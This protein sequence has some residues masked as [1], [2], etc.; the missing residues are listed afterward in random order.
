M[1]SLVKSSRLPLAT[2]IAALISLSAAPQKANAASGD[3]TATA[4]TPASWATATNWSS[5]PTVPGSA[6][7]DVI[8][9]NSNIAAAYTI[10]LDGTRTMG[11][12]LV[13]DSDTTAAFTLA[14]GTSGVLALDGTGTT[15]ALVRFGVAGSTLGI[16]NTISAPITLVDNARFYT[17]LTAA[18]Q[19]VSGAVSGT[20]KS[21]TFDNDDGTTLAGPV[22][23]Q[24]QYF[25]TGN[26]TYTGGTTIDD[27][28]VRIQTNNTALGAAGSAVVIQ[29]GGQVFNSTGLTNINYTFTIAGNGW[30]E[31]AGQLGA[32]RLD[33]G[34][35][36]TGTVAMSANAAIGSN[37]GTGTVSG[38]ISGGFA[39][40]KVGV[41]TITLGGVN[42]YTG[43]TTIA[44]GTVNVSTIGNTGVTGNLGTNST[45]NLGSGS[46]NGI[47]NYTGAGETNNRVLN[48][49]G[50]SGG[51]NVNAN[52][53]GLLR[54]TSN[55]TT[56]G[57]G[58]KGLNF[59]GSGNGQL[60]GTI[61][62]NTG[63][64]NFTKSGT[65]TWNLAGDLTLG[66]GSITMSGGAL[67]LGGNVSLGGGSI[68]VTAGTLNLSGNASLG[69]GNVTVGAGTTVTMAGVNSSTG[70]YTV[71]AGGR[72][73]LTSGN[74]NTSAI[75]VNGIIGGEGSTTG[76][77]TMNSASSVF[78]TVAAPNA[79]IKSNGVTFNATTGLL[80]DA[81]PV[82]G[83]YTVV[84]YG[85]A[86]DPS[87]VN[88]IGARGGF[89][90]DTTDGGNKKVIAAVSVADRTW[91]TT[92]GIWDTGVTTSW[93]EGDQKFF[94][95]DS[96][97]F[98]EPAAPSTVTLTG[99]LFPAAITVNNTTNSYT[100]AGT[101]TIG[102]SASLTKTGAGTLTLNSGNTFTGKTTV[103][104]GVLSVASD[105]S[106]GA[107]PVASV[108]DQLSLN[109]TTLT[110][111]AAGQTL[112]ATRGI[113]IGASSAIFDTS[114]LAVASVTTVS[115]N[116]IGSNG[117]TIAAN[118]DLSAS[119]AGNGGLFRLG[120]NNSGLTGG[121]AITAGLVAGANNNSFGVNTI[122]LSN[123][124]G[125][126]DP[127]VNLTLTNDIVVAAS[128]GTIRVYG[129]ATTNLNGNIS[130]TGTLQHT[131]GGTLR[132][133]GAGAGYLGTFENRRGTLT[134]TGN[135]AN[136]AGTDINL[137]TAGGALTF[138]G[139]GTATVNSVTSTRDVFIQNGM[140]LDVDSGVI[141][142]NTNGHWWQTNAGT[143]GNLTSSGGTLTVTNGAATGSL[144]VLDHQIRVKLVDFNGV[145]P[146]AFVKNNNN[147]L[148]V[149]QANTFTGGTTIN[150][151]R[152]N[153]D[154]LA[155]FGA[156]TVTVNNGGQTYLTQ[157]GAYANNFVLNGN[158]VVEAAGTLG[159]LRMGGNSVGSVTVASPAR[160]VSTSTGT[161]NGTL[162]GSAALE[163]N[164]TDAASTGTVSLSG[165]GAGYTGTAT[166]T[167]GRFNFASS[168]GGS[169]VVADGASLGAGTT[170]GADLTLGATTGTSY[171]A[172]AS[173]LAITGN[174]TLNGVS[175][176]TFPPPYPAPGTTTVPLMTYGGT[177][178]GTGAN[179]AL[180]NVASYR[181]TPAFDTT[182][183]GQVNLTG[184]DIKNLTWSG[185]T[186]AWNIKT[187]TNWNANV[188]VFATADRV[189]F[190]DTGVTTAVTLNG[191]L[192]PGSVTVSSTAN[193]YVLTASAGNVIGG[194]SS[195]FK[196]GTSTLTMAGNVAH[197]F[198]GGTTISQGAINVQNAGSLGTGTVTLGDASTGANNIALY[199]DTNRTTFAIP[200]VI[201]NNGSGT[202]TIGSRATV[203]GAGDN[204]QFTNIT[205]QRDAIFDSN[206]AD[207][208]DYENVSGTGNITVTGVGRSVFITPNTF[209]GNLNIATTGAGYF[210]IGTA[211][212]GAF[213]YIPDAT[214][215]TVQS[216][217]RF[218]VSVGAETIDALNG[219]GLVNVNAINA[220]LTVG[221]AGGSGD[222]GGVLANATSI[223]SLTKAG[224][225]TQI[226]SGA[227]TYTGATTINGGTLQVGNG[228]A[229][230]QLGTGAVT[231]AAGTKLT[232]NRSGAVGQGALNSTAVGNGT[233]NINGGAELSL[234]AGGNFSGIVN[235]NNGTLVFNT[236]N[237]TG[238]AASSATFNLSPGTTL[239]NT[240]NSTHGHIGNITL[241]AATWTTG[242]G[243]GNY[244]TQN[245]QLNGIVTVTG[246]APST[247]TRE[248]GRTDANSGIGLNGNR[249]FDVS[250]VTGDA[251]ADL[252]VSTELEN[253]DTTPADDGLTKIGAGTMLLSNAN[254]YS[255]PTVISGGTLR[256][257]AVLSLGGTSS[258]TVNP[259]AKLETAGTNVIVAGHGTAVANSKVITLNNATWE[260]TTAHDA[261]IGNVTLNNGS[262]WT[263]NR[264]L[265]N[266]DAL[267]ANTTTGPAT[268]AVTGT[269]A[270][271]M[272]GTGGV[273]LQDVQNFDVANTTL[274]SDPDLI[275]SL[276]LGNAGTVGGAAGGVN[277][278]GAGT[279]TLSAN[280]TYTGAT[281]VNAGTLNIDGTLG[282]GANVVN[283][284]AGATNFSVSQTL[285]ALNIGDGAVVT[286][287]APAPA[288]APA[289]FASEFLAASTTQPVPEPGSIALLLAGLLSVTARR[290]RSTPSA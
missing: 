100:F 78:M 112:S 30:L 20:G 174:L 66:G 95:G 179:L 242:A 236:T 215:V 80:F 15:T 25:V 31:S 272:N 227:N 72:L 214:S 208:T 76:A 49:N 133:G 56:T 162:T 194:P 63:L 198:T 290:R 219:A 192:Q 170:L 121:I 207:R 81:A 117:L 163:I 270:S 35:I 129:T 12:L 196:S 41:G 182:T 203:T 136:W 134:F 126:L 253:T 252:I 67:I 92:S 202:A 177:L 138:S 145:T 166:V 11:S 26:N 69:S 187:A 16:G 104:G 243:T 183:P 97:T 148:N 110:F 245:Y 186:G 151:G 47:L 142:L 124:A 205:L 265:T 135:N 244:F 213:N 225:G 64:M 212:A 254:S 266:Y 235:L 260:M 248:A 200:V 146:L 107:A 153:A 273:H 103:T 74:S 197:T 84:N 175:T 234:N 281:N 278:L 48:F 287:G 3:W 282:A 250:D 274:N 246:S 288:P 189:V 286:L 211:S 22:S 167:K 150:G 190:D 68:T 229:T 8:N 28:R 58:A 137:D 147:S 7:G 251:A 184:L 96:V 268:V 14:A 226:L 255:A 108:P 65:G 237:P 29:D 59:G 224:A 91:N 21:V 173:P 119:G 39:L 2:S 172:A 32:L 271:V 195:L 87:L 199:L 54:F 284:N 73:I 53:T 42:T 18:E 157:A 275:V 52:G 128:G 188:D 267:L 158:G 264:V 1:K 19:T 13:G 238:T 109:G 82:S 23:N 144:T 83:N 216:G 113:T 33:S 44:S 161:I 239:T 106:L 17:T 130:G 233:L 37:S 127:N 120:G 206:A 85:S 280:N 230:G 61:T 36:V 89:S 90:L 62:N 277:K 160:I 5:N 6:A 220:T 55:T 269:G 34:A 93:A 210:Q 98:N 9:I 141:A 114:A 115:G 201:S 263:S 249:T 209:I 165:S 285:G 71:A 283:A 139:G 140:T 247:I 57:A 256:V 77:L 289:E 123:N 118:G 45:I 169:I 279:M 94:G 46:V 122:T 132:L 154:N 261:R 181:G 191:N 176:V 168:F 51:G 43:A 262:T 60:D 105:S 228:G 258:I 149:N 217:A 27:V 125:I 171:F 10:N 152:I 223:F 204:N 185:A 222:F 116:I 240:T 259:G 86:A 221:A 99:A 241:N 79:S 50:T 88:L 143:V 111:S 70:V 75:T 276:I 232:Y 257:T 38:V 231:L 193:N 4:T 24:G 40:S 159:A 101:G 131:D 102:G 218:A 164:S 178:V 180:A 156:G 155:A